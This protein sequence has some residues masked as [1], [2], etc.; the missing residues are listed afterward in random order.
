MILILS[1]LLLVWFYP[2]DVFNL[3][4]ELE[5]P[6]AYD[7]LLAPFNF[8]IK[9]TNTQIDEERNSITNEFIPYYRRVN[10]GQQKAELF[11]T[12]FQ[13]LAENYNERTFNRIQKFGETLVLD[14]YQTGILQFDDSYGNKDVFYLVNNNLSE[15][16]EVAKF[17]TEQGMPAFIDEQLLLNNITEREKVLAV[18]QQ[19]IIPNIITD[20]KLNERLWGQALD[21][22]YP[23]EGAV[24]KGETI[25]GKGEIVEGQNYQK[26]LSLKEEYSKRGI[27]NKWAVNQLIGYLIITFLA[28]LILFLYITYY[29]KWLFRGLRKF[30]FLFISII[31]FVGMVRLISGFD[32]HIAYY[33]IPFAIIPIIF[34]SFF[35]TGLFIYVFAISSVLS[36][37]IIPIGLDYFV[38]QVLVALAAYE[39]SS[40][41]YYWSQ[42]FM[43]IGIVL[44]TYI[45]A[46]FGLAF[47][48]STDISQISIQPLPYFI[49][50]ALLT[51]LAYPL[52]AFFERLFGF[53][54]T[55]TLVELGD[56]NKPLL[57]QLQEKAPGTFW[58]SL[59]VSSLA[60][61]AAREINAD[62]LM[63][64]VGALYHDIGKMDNPL[65]FIENQQ[66]N[67][68]PHDELAPELSAQ[69]IVRHVTDGIEKAK[70]SGLPNAIIDFIRTHH[71][72]TRVR[73][74][75][76]KYIEKHPDEA[77]DDNLFEYPGPLPFSSETAILMLADSVDA[78]S[79]SLKNPTKEQLDELVDN[80]VKSKIDD[81]QLENCPLS[82]K[83]IKTIKKTFKRLLQSKYHL[84]VTY[85]SNLAN[86]KPKIERKDVLVEQNPIP[87]TLQINDNDDD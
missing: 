39:A 48:R 26:L 68:N 37:F 23:Y 31:L 43:V 35:N 74:F 6:W 62:A 25:I 53:I 10:V 29:E 16:K 8:P 3:N 55:L 5:K 76:N 87:A 45:I 17:H 56:L 69:I 40:R 71:G 38:L 82:F 14:I 21:N 84:R 42:F 30:S 86:R 66:T 59:Q 79:M 2:K 28:L 47:V 20:T 63:V 15:L 60:E 73:Y 41:T 4:F 50:N 1:T 83:N 49:V 52:I 33:A 44:L 13:K 54:S 67:V 85:P 70:R 18:I 72:N 65:Y 51:L 36:T 80:V 46:Y 27:G 19:C 64:K 77:V 34:R 81:G 78:A 9:K 57:K 24:Q 7:D 75:Y 32:S 11:K 58:H 22:I 61:A 12:Q